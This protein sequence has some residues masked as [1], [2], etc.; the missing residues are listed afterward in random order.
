[1]SFSIGT[2]NLQAHGPGGT[3]RAFGNIQE[4]K[5]FDLKVIFRLFAYLKPHWHRMLGA[6]LLMVAAAGLSLLA[7]YLI[8]LAIDVHIVAGDLGGLS[9]TAG[10]LAATFVGLYFAHAGQRYLLSWVGQK[11][12]ATLRQELFSHL[13]DIHLGYHDTHIVGVTVSRVINDVAII[14]E[15]LSQGLVTFVGDALLLGGIVAMMMSLSPTLALL[16]FSVMPL[17]LVATY[18]FA[19]KARVAF[20]A[21]RSRIAAVVGDLAQHLDGMRVIQAFAQEKATQKRFER[22][23]RSN[24]DSHVRAMSL[25]FVFLPVVEFLAVLATAVVLW[26]GGRRVAADQMTLGTMVAFLAY[27]T[28]FFLPIQEL[29]QIYTTMQA[30][31]AGGEK[32]LNLMDTR[33]MV[34]DAPGAIKLDRIGGKVEFRDVS[35]SYSPDEPVLQGVSVVVEPGQNLALVGQTGAGKTTMANLT[36]RFYDVVDGAILID[37]RDIRQV[38]QRSLR[39]QMGLVSQDPI[40]FAGTIAEN[41]RFGSPDAPD[42]A[43]FRAARA[44]NAHDFVSRLPEGY[45]T[46]VQEGGVN[47]SNGQRQLL[48]IARA[49]LADPRIILLDEATASVDTLTEALIQE[50]LER[51]FAERT[52]IVIAHRLSTVRNADKI[53]VLDQGRIMERGTHEELLAGRG[54]YRELYDRQFISVGE[55]R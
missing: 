42:E 18:L 52:S 13:Q 46:A 32:V 43:V 27:V 17:M 3:L 53:C 33:P 5:A 38:E 21:T 41:I 6:F 1:M 16:T 10:L 11:V 12:L 14:N 37:D 47:L 22:V 30:A 4:G 9:V 25:S 15:F 31:M 7:P 39:S 8:K 36:A 24:R 35:F 45:E 20:S 44:A 2:G 29:S 23:N 48:C 19:R 54:I 51:L 49:L 28:R 34:S 26:F 55:E 50:A 40:L